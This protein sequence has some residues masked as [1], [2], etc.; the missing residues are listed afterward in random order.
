[1]LDRLFERCIGSSQEWTARV[2]TEIQKS[3]DYG[4]FEQY[5]SLYKSS[6]LR[7]C[8]LQTKLKQEVDV[9]SLITSPFFIYMTIISKQITETLIQSE[10]YAL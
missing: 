10:I 2:S 7:S 9:N 6:Q 5:N 8:F 3:L 4:H 1:M